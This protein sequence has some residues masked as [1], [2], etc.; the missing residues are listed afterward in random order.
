[1]WPIRTASSGTPAAAASRGAAL[2][3]VLRRPAPQA[4]QARPVLVGRLVRRDAERTDDRELVDRVLE[5]ALGVA[6]DG[7]PALGLVRLEQ[8]GRG[9]PGEHGGELPAQV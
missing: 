8:L 4:P 1:M 7:G 5:R 9:G 6:L 3:G 2:L